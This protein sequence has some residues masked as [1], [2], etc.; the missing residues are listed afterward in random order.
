MTG[1]GA[2]S[3]TAQGAGLAP[4]PGLQPERT[5]LAWRRTALAVAAVSL[6]GARLLPALFGHAVWLLPGLAG[7]GLA[8]YLWIAARRRHARRTPVPVRGPGPDS[9]GAGLLALTGAVGVAI[10]LGALAVVIS[11]HV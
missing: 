9:P 7:T 10:G 5:E 6:V 11:L 4:A 1:P 2:G 8:G 3:G